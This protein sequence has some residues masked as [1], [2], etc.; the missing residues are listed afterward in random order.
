MT[1]DAG[2]PAATGA[3]ASGVRVEFG[4]RLSRPVALWMLAATLGLLM[5]ASAAPS[6]MYAVYQQA[7]GFSPIV[8]TAVYAANALALLVTLLFVGSLSDHLGRRPVLLVAMI[9]EL[10]GMVV[11]AEAHGV[12]WLVAGRVLQGVATGL[13]TGA[14]SATLIDL[15]PT[16]SRLGAL[17]T[18]VASSGG[19]A[20][21]ALGS[22]L[23]VAY[24]PNP[25]GLVYWLLT[26]AFVLALAGIAAMPETVTRDGGAL[27]SLAPKVAVPR[28]TRGAFFALLPSI[29]ATWALGGLYLALG[30]SLVRAQLH[31]SSPLAGGLVIVVLQGTASVMA[32]L[33]RDWSPDKALR[34]GPWWLIGGV[35]L[36]LLGLRL[37]SA[38]L[39]YLASAVAGIGFGP[40]FSGALRTLT[41]LAPAARR[42]EMVTAIYTVS[43]LALSVPAVAAG[44]A[45]AQVGL[46]DT[47]Y[48]YGAMVIVL[49]AV[50]VV[51]SA[52]HR[53]SAPASAG[54]AMVPG[55]GTVAAC[56][57]A[58][59]AHV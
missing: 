59:A 26:A 3:A 7:W 14:I 20:V 24:G 41:G 51:A 8:L 22:G 11:F 32:V 28:E 2:D 1:V 23:L 45:V 19:I 40:S 55:P 6:P 4:G 25:T 50:A 57:R 37:E 58:V 39:F 52:R 46:R 43:Y 13:A 47:A 16:G 35:A 30:G 53:G 36:A 48:A 54:P 18:N 5:F 17:L 29:A 44:I 38:W 9:V 12:G 42:A 49:E 31:L 21:G 27:K 10:V 56:P 33:A 34:R 15:Q